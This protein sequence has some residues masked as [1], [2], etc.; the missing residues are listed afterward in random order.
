MKKKRGRVGFQWDWFGDE[1]ANA[2]AT[3]GEPGLWRAGQMVKQ[4]AQRRAPVRT[5][6][7]RR[8]LYVETTKRNDYRKGRRDRRWGRLKVRSD[9]TV[10][11]ATGAWYGNL[12][13]DSGASPHRIPY[14]GRLTR[15]DGS[16]RKVLRIPG[17]GF[18]STAIHPGMRRD[19]FL[20]PA[21]NAVKDRLIEAIC[22][23]MEPEIVRATP[24]A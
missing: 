1:I 18:R 10:L 24:D 2:V 5:G 16:A 11:I 7:M 13:E 9:D 21:L 20:A 8:S 4:E 19:P 14:R 23:Q 17:L 22:D 12:L 15:K 3:Q 6:E